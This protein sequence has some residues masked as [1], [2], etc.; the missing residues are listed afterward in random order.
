VVF[1]V[2]VEAVLDEE[3]VLAKDEDA[4]V[5]ADDGWRGVRGRGCG[6]VVQM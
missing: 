2:S 4:E 6:Q 3:A 5:E 1:E